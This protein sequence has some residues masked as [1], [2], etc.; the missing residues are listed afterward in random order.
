MSWIDFTNQVLWDSP[1]SDQIIIYPD[2]EDEDED[3]FLLFPYCLPVFGSVHVHC[4]P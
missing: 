4:F 1:A 3:R 2:F